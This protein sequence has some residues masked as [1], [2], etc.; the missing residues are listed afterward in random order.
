MVDIGKEC[1]HTAAFYPAQNEDTTQNGVAA[2]QIPERSL[3]SQRTRFGDETV[4]ENQ[5]SP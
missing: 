3:L 4:S 2:N 1:G 5:I